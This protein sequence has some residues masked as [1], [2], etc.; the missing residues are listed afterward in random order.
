MFQTLGEVLPSLARNF[1]APVIC[2][3]SQLESM[4]VGGAFIEGENWAMQRKGFDERFC[5]QPYLLEFY[6]SLRLSGKAEQD[7]YR[8]GCAK[9]W[10]P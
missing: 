1:G 3:A 8:G 9:Y 6:Q 10:W 7:G 2:L 5:R 4:G